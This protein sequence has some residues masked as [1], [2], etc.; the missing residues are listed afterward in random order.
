MEKNYSPFGKSPFVYLLLHTKALDSA[1]FFPV[2]FT[3]YEM[4]NTL[5]T[6]KSFCSGQ[7]HRRT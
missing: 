3:F 5:L 7:N 6:Q 2:T 4:G 1:S